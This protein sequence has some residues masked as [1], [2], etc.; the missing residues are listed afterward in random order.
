M[1]VTLGCRAGGSNGE[2]RPQPDPEARER[3]AALERSVASLQA[4]ADAQARQLR[5]FDS[6]RAMRA[7]WY[8]HDRT[9]LALVSTSCNIVGGVCSDTG[10]PPGT[11][12]NYSWLISEVVGLA[13][14][15]FDIARAKLQAL[16]RLP[17]SPV[18]SDS[19]AR[20]RETRASAESATEASFT[21]CE[22]PDAAP[23]ASA[24]AAPSP[25]A[26]P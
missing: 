26:S 24:S 25:S 15:P 9:V 12:Q 18:P 7:A 1:F 5:C 22:P 21:A 8:A 11:F 13:D 14:A 17:Q 2:A 6:Q 20:I 10:L 16:P 3:I 19:L 4:N 23:S